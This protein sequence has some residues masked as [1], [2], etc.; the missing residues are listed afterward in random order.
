MIAGMEWNGTFISSFFSIILI[1]LML[2]GDNAVVIAMAVRNLPNRV[3]RW[4]IVLGTGGA[5]LVRVACTFVIAQLLTM[6][7]IKLV[8]GVIIL[9]VAVKLLADTETSTGRD[10]AGNLWQ[11]LCF[12]VVADMS[13]G[14]D[15]ML[16]VGAASHGNWLLILFGLCFSMP[17]VVFTSSWLARLMDQQPLVVVVGAALLG[18]IGGEMIITD[19]IVQGHFTL[20]GGLHCGLLI[21]S[22][23]T[24][25]VAGK[26]LQ[27]VHAR[28][29]PLPD[30]AIRSNLD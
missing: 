22:A 13:M 5:I 8:G 20:P 25:V 29:Q 26:Y 27:M 28:N 4:G 12:I 9:W 23:V 10:P 19:P 14:V 24:V 15:N 18:K 16:A 7:Y 30:T 3:R 6:Q 17:F 21:L 1:D 11:A 2:A